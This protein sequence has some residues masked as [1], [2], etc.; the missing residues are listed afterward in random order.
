[1]KNIFEV[2]WDGGDGKRHTN[3]HLCRI[4]FLSSCELSFKHIDVF[5]ILCKLQLFVN[6]NL[7]TFN[8]PAPP[9]H[10]SFF[11]FQLGF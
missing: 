2:N 9:S 3:V 4:P 8:L 10:P 6:H 1:M 11:F 7:A 5:L